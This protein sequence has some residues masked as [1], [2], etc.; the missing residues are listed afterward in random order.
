MTIEQLKKEKIWV[1]W[2]GVPQEDGKI[3]KVP[4]AY[5]GRETGCDDAHQETWTTYENVEGKLDGTSFALRNGVGVIDIDSNNYDTPMVKDIIELMDTYTEIS[6]SGNGYHLIF[7][8]DITKIP[9]CID[10]EGKKKLDSKY[11]MKNKE[12]DIEC[13]ISG[14]TNRFMTYTGDV[15]LDK[16]IEDRTEQ[17]LIFLNK[18]MKKPTQDAIASNE[19][20]LEEVSQNVLEIIIHSANVAKFKKLYNEG[21]TENYNGDD[22]SADLALCNILA[23]YCGNNPELIDYMFSQS[24]L[25]REKWDRQDYKDRTIKL[26][27][28]SCNGNFYN[29]GIDLMLLNCFNKNNIHKSYKANDV[30][31]GRLFATTY[32][33]KLRYNTTE[34]EWMFYNGQVWCIDERSMKAS[35]LMKTF[36]LTLRQYSL[37]IEDEKFSKYVNNLLNVKRRDLLL[38]DSQDYFPISQEELDTKVNLLNLQNGTFNFDTF[39]LQPHNANDLLSK[40]ANVSYIPNVK[41]ERWEKFIEEVMEGNQAKINYLQKVFGYS[42]LASNPMNKF[43]ILYGKTRSGKGTLTGT[44]YHLLGGVN[45]YSATIMP[46]SLALHKDKDGST[47]SPDIAKL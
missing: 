32:K 28:A 17:V 11:Y 31:M 16:P 2:K 5:N 22:S 39:E 3:K 36:T 6:P 19:K 27:I 12:K 24:Q 37:K 43:F 20:E 29:T 45:G 33:D 38:K 34:K 35:A 21:N 1:N 44:I 15:F 30:D 26:A 4:L 13:Y 41:S 42:L 9:T 10:A 25:Y 23:F 46:R 8:V 14:L 40:V 7:T 18:Y 47:A